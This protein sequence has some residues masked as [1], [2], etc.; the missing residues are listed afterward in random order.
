LLGELVE[1]AF[2]PLVE[3]SLHTILRD[4]V[5][6][7]RLGWAFL[8]AQQASRP[9]D[10]V[11]PHLPAMLDATVGEELFQ[12]GDDPDPLSR[13]ISGLGCLDRAVSRDV[14]RRTL[15]LVVFP[16]LAHFGV[17]ISAGERW[18]NERF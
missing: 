15:K 17:D 11:G 10:C 12:Q 16:G 4:E 1:R 13:E 7:S 14:T 18:L 6:H 9:R 8:E 5:T 3:E 2:D